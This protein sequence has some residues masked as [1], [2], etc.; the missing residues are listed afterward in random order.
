[1]SAAVD[2]RRC[3]K[4]GKFRPGFGCPKLKR[5]GKFKEKKSPKKS[6]RWHARS[7]VES[8][9]KRSNRD[10]SRH[11][12]KEIN[13]PSKLP[14]YSQKNKER[15]DENGRRGQSATERRKDAYALIKVGSEG[16]V[17]K[18]NALRKRGGGEVSQKPWLVCT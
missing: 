7:C 13:I 12:G 4:E 1:L 3:K 5:K 14:S 11:A 2:I 9:K 15:D 6:A 18:T 8:K 10:A 17:S 16:F